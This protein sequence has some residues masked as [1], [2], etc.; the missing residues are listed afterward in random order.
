MELWYRPEALVALG[1][2]NGASVSSWPDSGPKGRNLAQGTGANQPTFVTSLA[3]HGGRPAVQF[4]SAGTQWLTAT[5]TGSVWGTGTVFVVCTATV[6]TNSSPSI[7]E[8]GNGTVNTGYQFLYDS[9]ST[10]FR[11]RNSGGNPQ[12]GAGTL[13]PAVYPAIICGVFDG[14]TATLEKNGF[15][16]A[17]S[18]GGSSTTTSM[19]T[20]DVGRANWSGGPMTGYISEVIAYSRALTAAERMQVVEYLANKY[21][22]TPHYNATSPQTTPTPD[23]S[24]N[25]DEPGILY[26]PSGWNGYKYWLGTTPYPSSNDSLENPTIRV[27]N[28]GS[29]WIAPPGLTID[30]V[31]PL[32][33]VPGQPTVHNA[34]AGLVFDPTGNSGAGTLYLFGIESDNLATAPVGIKYKSTNDGINWSSRAL[35]DLGTGPTR[36]T[37]PY[38]VRKSDGTY[39]AF[40]V[41]TTGTYVHPNWTVARG[42]ASS[43]SGT[44]SGWTNVITQANLDSNDVAA[45]LAPWHNTYWYDGGTLWCFSCIKN[46]TQSEARLAIG[47]STDD[48]QTWTFARSCILPVGGGQQNVFIYQSTG[49][50]TDDRTAFRVWYGANGSSIAGQ[51]RLWYTLI[52]RGRGPS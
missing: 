35:L 3:G 30:P 26:F 37:S 29:T 27:S 33:E 51:W 15:A 45:S 2:S 12:P 39:I 49:F 40:V 6:G 18:G 14:T 47:K 43:I 5:W 31:F 44:F 48:G 28:D 23:G 38:I 32:S 52:P 11:T 8:I 25:F 41:Q 10:S 13:P 36:F 50:L 4:S 34:D 17:T 1:L 42:T 9:G 20:I 46:N 24:G 16:F 19:S 7:L 22:F 21:S